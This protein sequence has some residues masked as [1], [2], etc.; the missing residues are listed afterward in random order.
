[1]LVLYPKEDLMEN[2]LKMLG[3]IV[4]AGL[5]RLSKPPAIEGEITLSGI[6]SSVRIQRDRWGVP[7]IQADTLDDVFFA[8]GF[9]QAQER[10]FQMD[11]NRRMVAGELAAIIGEAALPLDRWM[12][13]L[14]MRRV[15]EKEAAILCQS[16]R[17][18][19]DAFARGVSAWIKFGSLPV[20]FKLLRY[21]P[22]PW[23]PADTLAWAK[24]IGWSLSVNW[25][26]EILR[27]MLL[28]RLGK[29]L[30]MQLDPNYLP[31]WPRALP[32]DTD[33]S[34]IGKR[35]LERAHA[36]RPFT[37]LSTYEGIG[38]NNW[39]VCGSRTDSG[40][41]LLANDMHL[42]LAIPSI[43]Y[44]N[45]L[46]CP[47]LDVIGVTF[48]GVPGVI[49]GHNG[50]V[51]WGFTNGFPDVQDLFMERLRRTDDGNVQT[52][53]ND[54]WFNTKVLKEVIEIKN[55]Q[56]VIEEVIVTRHGPIINHMA[57]EL[58]DDETHL[59][60]CWSALEPDDCVKSVMAINQAANC[61]EIYNALR[62]WT[63]PSQNV[64]YADAEGNIAYTLPGKIPIR[65]IGDG[66]FPVP[67]WTD[68]YEWA[69][70]IPFDDLPHAMNPAQG[71]IA[72]ANNRVAPDDYP[73]FLGRDVLNPDRSIRIHT[74]IESQEK[75]SIEFMVNMQ[76]DQISYSAKAMASHLGELAL[77][78]PEMASITSRMRA[79]DGHLSPSS[80]EAAIYEVFYRRLIEILLSERL[81]DFTVETTQNE[82]NGVEAY[83]TDFTERYKGKGPTPILAE[84]SLFGYRAREWLNHVLE[85]PDSHWFDLGAGQ[86]REQVM[87]MA[88]VDSVQYLKSKFGPRIE[89][90]SWGKLHRLHLRH[91]LGSNPILAEFL[92]RGP[93]PIG[94]D[95][96]T[97][98]ASGSIPHQPEGDKISG[99]AYRMIVDLANIEH[100][101]A[102]LLPGNS[103]LP[104]SP[105]YTDQIDD[106]FQGNY[107]PM[108][109]TM[110][111]LA[112]ESLRT[113]LIL[114]TNAG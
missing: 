100:S 29:D 86:T 62:H 42:P 68:E 70:Y 23:V 3:P 50:K 44:E 46:T 95:N 20:E 80:P 69:G 43:W 106:W 97:L 40:K 36:A 73:Y 2:I 113:L 58:T 1:V 39:A 96:T 22:K 54:Q 30:L 9:A 6:K 10:L 24:M 63:F 114:P 89:D 102:I 112:D 12:R 25:E 71:F 37:G 49:S 77:D 104:T 17:N 32:P 8:Q 51:A 47:D 98:W 108:L 7:H 45:H 34:Q 76:L 38:S 109:F 103:G 48:P 53:Y 72:T 4:S 83:R 19:L 16:S 33:Y 57:P 67:G 94:G 56:P 92:N 101:R 79:W 99:P 75:V 91:P 27:A 74:L 65:K 35:A 60:L 107:H 110:Q 28:E 88:L 85:N 52:E 82:S 105:H 111:Q 90:W 11:F 14:T 5:S 81:D 61:Q 41:P 66:Q 87:S 59:A 64:V 21:K 84:S 93:F 13:T 15:A 26:T 78:L 55:S 31:E 18:V